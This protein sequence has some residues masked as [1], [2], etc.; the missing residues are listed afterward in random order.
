MLYIKAEEM[1][2]IGNVF[3]LIAE[4]IKATTTNQILEVPED[5]VYRRRPSFN[6]LFLRSKHI[7]A[8]LNIFL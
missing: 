8:M 5:G 6:Y 3:K 1:I 4:K 2:D 7:T